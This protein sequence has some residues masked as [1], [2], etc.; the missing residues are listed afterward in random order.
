MQIRPKHC[1]YAGALA[2]ALIG[3]ALDRALRS[4]PRD[5]S[6]AEIQPKPQDKP[7]SAAAAAAP[8]G[9]RQNNRDDAAAPSSGSASRWLRELPEVPEARDLFAPA[10]LFPAAS[11]GDA[12]G[13][14]GKDNDPIAEFIGAHRLNGTFHD[15]R[16]SCAV[17]NGR[18]VR[19]GQV[20]DGF[21]LTSVD[22]FRATFR[23]GHREAVLL[24]NVEDAWRE[25]T[26]PQ[27]K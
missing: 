24:M 26:A 7:P 6:A 10:N 18:V 11:D 22:S 13:A 27:T 9:S 12:D 21:R 3:F 4:G 2:L 1:V 19:P 20:M 8:A 17:V 25:P 16:T 23:E 5:V 14:N 15:G